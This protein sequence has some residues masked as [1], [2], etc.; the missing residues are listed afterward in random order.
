MINFKDIID[1]YRSNVR[2]D[3]IKAWDVIEGMG[4]TL[5]ENLS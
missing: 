4:S 1:Y 3:G 2:L 5:H